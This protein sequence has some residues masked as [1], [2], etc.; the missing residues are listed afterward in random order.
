MAYHFVHLYNNFSGS[1]AVLKMIVSAAQEYT[2]GENITIYSSFREKGFLSDLNVRK[3]NIFYRRVGIRLVDYCFVCMSLIYVFFSGLC[4]FRKNDI[5]YCNTI[6]PFSAV[7][8]GA[9]K[10]ADVIV[11]LHESYTSSR[12][13]SAV[14]RRVICRFA[15]TVVYPSEYLQKAIDLPIE[16]K[17]IPSLSPNIN[18]TRYPAKHTSE[19]FIVLMA[20][21]FRPYKGVYKFVELA[22]N[23]RLDK[24]CQFDLLISDDNE[25]VDE[26]LQDVAY[27]T[28]LRVIKRP[29]N[30]EEYFN[31]AHLILNLTNP[32]VCIE[33]F[34]LTV[35]EGLSFG[36]PALVPGV[37]GPAEIVRDGIEG[38]HLRSDSVSECTQYISRLRSDSNLYHRLSSAALA[39]SQLY[40]D[41]TFRRCVELVLNPTAAGKTG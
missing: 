32:E 3:K 5:V 10:G 37:G 33:S 11:H 30:V 17:I 25:S 9:I 23:L 29:D 20:S 1:P 8:A 18:G 38:Y 34:G 26:F 28:N 21:S 16:S 27:L 40:S 31:S 14:S 41:K 6:M 2:P 15:K 12:L 4:N 24:G 13:Y 39:R 35:L 7:I 36:C 22:K 19:P